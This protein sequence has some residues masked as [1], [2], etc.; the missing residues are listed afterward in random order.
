M[1]YL[2]ELSKEH[3]TIPKSEIL[4]CLKAEKI[5][6][7]TIESNTDALIIE[8]DTKPDKIKQISDRLSSTFYVNKLKFSCLPI[9]E[10]INK[11]ALENQI[12]TRGTIAIRH[13][14][15]SLNI[16]SQEIIKTLAD[17]YTKNRKVKLEKPDIEIRALITDKRVYISQ[18]ISQID[19]TQFEKR[20]VQYR[21]F[22]SPI[23]LHPRLARALVN[24][25]NIQ[26]NKVLLDPFCGT[27]GILL[28]AG[29]IGVK[30]IG[31]DI[32]EK[33]IEGCKKTLSHYNI[34]KYKLIPSDIGEIH[35][36]IDKVDA[37]VTD[38]PY[39]KSTT[40]K[41]EEKNQLYIRAFDK[42]SNILK[43]NCRAVIGLSNSDLISEGENFFTHVETH[44]IKAHRSLTRYFAVY[45][46][47][48]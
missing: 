38:L 41:G 12:K 4:S 13:K 11:N 22:F 39:G 10:D 31:S 19:R 46:K 36:H 6:Y 20:K 24:L 37:V 23:T 26:K 47:Q 8:T 43:N 33:M 30:I 29:L 5:K 15:R 42:I 16:E 2:F 14:N 7:K 25:S 35:K 34:D 32:E 44:E 3:K 17:I 18:K 1:K 28:E 40:T 21:P 9:I 48:P 27:G 45:E